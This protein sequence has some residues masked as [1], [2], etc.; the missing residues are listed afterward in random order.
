MRANPLSLLGGALLGALLTSS[1]LAQKPWPISARPPIHTASE[2]YHVESFGSFSL[3]MLRGDFSSAV[4][5]GEAL[6]KHPSTGV[7]ALAAARGEITI[8]DGKAYLS[9]GKPGEHP[10][11]GKESATLLAIATAAQW[12]SV[13]VDRDVAPG[14][15]AAYIADAATAHGI[16]AAKSFPF[17]LTGSA[18]PY[19]MHVN[20]APID[21]KHGPDLPMATTVET[22]GEEIPGKI[23][24]LYV[25]ANL[26]GVVT[27][28][29]ERIHAHWLS[30]DEQWTAHLDRWGIKR[31]AVLLLPKP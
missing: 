5:L 22:K 9:Y 31:G 13:M 26:E 20:V 2:P 6:A 25:A 29:G 16:D 21:G 18:M 10:A 14:A 30:P 23:A 19:I 8:I 4:I 15:V 3:M 7:G 27:P 24:G 28:M 12:Q 17:E 1:A 11:P